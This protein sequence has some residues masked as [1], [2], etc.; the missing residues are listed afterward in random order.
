MRSKALIKILG[1][2][3]L[4]FR[5]GPVVSGEDSGRWK[6]RTLINICPDV[7][8]INDKEIQEANITLQRERTTALHYQV[9]TPQD[10][11]ARDDRKISVTYVCF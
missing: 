1:S 5:S 6:K 9:T 7:E 8:Y 11:D 4:L 2:Y 10:N 3:L